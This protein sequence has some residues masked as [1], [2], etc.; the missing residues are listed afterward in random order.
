MKTIAFLI[1]MLTGGIFSASSP[2]RTAFS[3]LRVVAYL[4]QP[5]DPSENL[6]YSPA[7]RSSWTLLKDRIIGGDIKLREDLPLV[8]RMNQMPY[9][10]P[11]ATDGIME[12]GFVESGIIGR[13]DSL[14]GKRFGEGPSGLDRFSRESNGIICF[15]KFRH[16]VD[17][18]VPF[19]SLRWTFDDGNG[20]VPVACF[21]VTKGDSRDKELMRKQVCLADYRNPDDFVMVIHGS[22][23]SREIVLAKTD[24]TGSLAELMEVTD[25]RIRQSYPD[26]LSDADELIIPVMNLSASKSYEELIGKYLSNKGFRDYFFAAATQA[27]SFRMDKTGARAEATGTV[28]LKK[29]PVPRI[30]AFDKPF[31]LVLRERG[32]AEPDLVIWVASPVILSS[33]R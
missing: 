13:I 25:E 12:A 9:R 7:F 22:D 18:P 26:S 27:V 14:L 15:S 30:Y 3:P 5:A 17:F 10:C 28:V 4:S 2:S 29:G 32:S 31:L 16:S 33:T 20:R 21:G 8:D 23:P 19:E 1:I 11:D 24:L 6:V